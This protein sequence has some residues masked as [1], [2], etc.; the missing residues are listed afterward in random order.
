MR[1]R[2]VGTVPITFITGSVGAV[3]RGDEFTVSEELA[4]AFLAR[5]DVEEVAEAVTETKVSKRRRRVVEPGQSAAADGGDP[6]KTSEENGDV[7]NDH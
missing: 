5:A 2:Y 1:L 4:P 6:E 3:K 7:P